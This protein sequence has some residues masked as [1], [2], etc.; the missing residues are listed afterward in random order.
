MATVDSLFYFPI[1]VQM[2][3]KG[4]VFFD[5]KIWK[6]AVKFNIPLIP[7]FLSQTVLNS[8]DRIMISNL[9]GQSE[10]GIY[11]LA[12][13]ISLVVNLFNNALLQS[14][15]PWTY[16]KLKENREED[17]E[18]VGIRSL[19]VIGFLDI[20][21]ISFAPE[22]VRFFAPNSY[23][24]AIWIIPPI[25]MSVF[26]QYMYAMFV[27]VELYQEK[28]GFIAV[29]TVI[30]AI[31]NIILNYICIK[32]FGYYA[33]GYTTLICYMLIA[34]LHYLFMEK[35]CKNSNLKKVI[36]SPGELLILSTA[37]L[38]WGFFILWTYKY[39]YIRYFS[40]CI[41]ILLLFVNREK[42][43]SVIKLNKEN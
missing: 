27:D 21:F 38:L 35:V 9:I 29:A 39:V 10:A 6:Y 26:F 36:Y 4:R 1:F 30:G 14:I 41:Y 20:L 32:L 18:K 22:I 42:I 15:S 33:A 17:I 23:F 13:Q 43:L 37:F 12:Y 11:S 8:A 3:K 28:T 16:K 24:N 19:V 34:L 5:E 31:S 7:H 2:Y 40:I 25:T